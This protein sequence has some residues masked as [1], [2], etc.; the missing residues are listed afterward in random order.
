M[1]REK[2][3]NKTPYLLKIR[4]NGDPGFHMDSFLCQASVKETT[5]AQIYLPL[6]LYNVVP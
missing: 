6:G 5:E 2:C 4:C 3:R 1:A